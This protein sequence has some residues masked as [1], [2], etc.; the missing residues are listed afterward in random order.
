MRVT[1][2]D[3]TPASLKGRR[4]KVRVF[5]E[6][7]RTWV[8]WPDPMS[9]KRRYETFPATAAG[10]KEARAFALGKFEALQ[11][12]ATPVSR[13]TSRQLWER[14]AASAFASLRPRSQMLYAQRW[15][16]W[17]IFIGADTIAENVPTEQV[18]LFRSDCG[19]ARRPMAVNQIR[20]IVRVVKVV[21]GWAEEMELIQ[22]NRVGRY[23]FKVGK[24][25]NVN[26]PAEYQSAQW[27]AILEALGGGQDGRKWK[28]WAAVMIAG[29]MGERINAILHLEWADVDLEL[30]RILW[31]KALNKQGR[32]REQPLTYEALSAL[33]TAR[34]WADRRAHDPKLSY[35]E[36]RPVG[37]YVLPM[38]KSGDRAYQYSGFH[39]QLRQAERVAGVPHSA[40][41]AAHGLRKMASGNVIESTGDPL[42]GLHWIGDED[43]RRLREYGKVREA[44]MQAIADQVTAPKSHG[45]GLNSRPLDYE[46]SAL[47]LSYHG[48]TAALLP[49][50]K[51]TRVVSPLS[52]PPSGQL[53]T[54]DRL[55]AVGIS[56]VDFPA[57]T[58][59][60]GPPEAVES[61][62]ESPKNHS[63]GAAEVPQASDENGGVA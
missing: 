19:K 40:L 8:Q 6:V 3:F 42:Q 28:A 43:P 61:P 25:E 1:R 14:Y 17:E 37:R 11:A 12:P 50:A 15:R 48:E 35:K 22:R 51:K 45:G 44:R 49:Q 18:A 7:G 63:E 31:P 27:E 26:E 38:A 39:Y 56:P 54:D 2:I 4:P 60:H 29:S 46:S 57:P 34:W 53:G 21:Y 13:L 20:Q 58:P 30:G 59:S 32:N 24:N 41:R 10:R 47:P 36:R 5:E 9:R 62:L 55:E 33:L 52:I 23:R 16:K